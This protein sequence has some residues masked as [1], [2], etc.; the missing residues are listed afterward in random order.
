M[1][2]YEERAISESQVLDRLAE[3]AREGRPLSLARFSHAEIAILTA[4][5]SD[6]DWIRSWEYTRYQGATAEPEELQKLLIEALA[7]ADITGLHLSTSPYEVDHQFCATS[8]ELLNRLGIRPRVVCSPWTTHAFN[9]MPA[10]WNL[11]RQYPVF[12]VGRRAPEAAWIFEREGV[13][14]AGTRV[15]EGVRNVAQVCSELCADPHWRIALIA[16]GIPATVLAPRLARESGRIAIDYGHAMD[17]LIEGENFD[18]Y[19]IA[20]EWNQKNSN[21]G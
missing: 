10:F 12:L 18:F 6:P 3:A 14:V 20:A 19:R 11:L 16:A 21:K 2:N 8:K 15:L 7:A 1:D 4:S 13:A 9:G 5:F 17:G